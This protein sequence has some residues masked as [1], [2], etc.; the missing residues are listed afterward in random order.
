MQTICAALR[1]CELKPT[2]N[3]YHYCLLLYS[4]SLPRYP[5]NLQSNETWALWMASDSNSNLPPVTIGSSLLYDRSLN[6]D[7]I[8]LLL[9]SKLILF[10]QYSQISPQFVIE[11]K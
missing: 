11:N 6:A 5:I 10:A 3:S 2:D 9:F 8:L 1:N 4:E 7:N